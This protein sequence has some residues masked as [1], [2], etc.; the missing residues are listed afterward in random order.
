M[1]LYDKIV[2]I[3]FNFYKYHNLPVTLKFNFEFLQ[4]FSLLSFTRIIQFP[5]LSFFNLKSPTEQALF[6]RLSSKFFFFIEKPVPRVLYIILDFFT[7]RL[8]V[9]EQTENENH[10][11]LLKYFHLSSKS[12]MGFNYRR[13]KQLLI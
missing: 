8:I 5:L 12:S 9:S 3:I 4:S 2:F 7:F 11:L 6:E 10:I 1:Y 13:T